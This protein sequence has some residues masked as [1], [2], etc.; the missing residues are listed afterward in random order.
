MGITEIFRSRGEQY[1]RGLEYAK[2]AEVRHGTG[3]VVAP[4]GDVVCYERN[5]RVPGK[6]GAVIALQAHAGEAWKRVGGGTG[7]SLPAFRG[8]VGSIGGKGRTAESG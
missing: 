6:A 7:R 8:R 5:G 4:G 3:H 2:L 1:L